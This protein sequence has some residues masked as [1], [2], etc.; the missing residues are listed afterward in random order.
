MRRLLVLGLV[1]LASSCPDFRLDEREFLCSGDE[2]CG[3]HERC[4]QGVCRA[5]GDAGT[6]EI[7]GNGEDDDGDELVDCRDP[8]CGVASCDDYNPCTNDI[9]LIDGMCRNVPASNGTACGLG[10]ICQAGMPVEVACGDGI[11]NDGDGD[12]DCHD[13]DCGCQAGTDLMCCP[14]GICRVGC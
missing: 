10:C 13:P 6:G 7:C 4:V 2:Q 11:D 9:C 14:D 8:D 5:L 1:L 3:E 12:L